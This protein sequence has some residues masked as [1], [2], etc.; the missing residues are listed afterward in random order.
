M[1]KKH[2]WQRTWAIDIKD[3]RAGVGTDYQD[4]ISD[5]IV[6][7]DEAITALQAENEGLKL[8][9]H[10]ADA[11]SAEDAKRISYRLDAQKT[12]T[13]GA[14]LREYARRLRGE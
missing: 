2:E 13:D 5:C 3:C 12:G 7:A 8:K 10:A 9:A 11:L 14:L 4:S 1:S 6:H